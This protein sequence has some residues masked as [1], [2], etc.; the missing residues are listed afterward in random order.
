[1]GSSGEIYIIYAVMELILI[2]GGPSLNGVQI[3]NSLGGNWVSAT[4]VVRCHVI[5]IFMV[6]KICIFL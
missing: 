3:A 1:M 2:V 4:T 6:G 5:I